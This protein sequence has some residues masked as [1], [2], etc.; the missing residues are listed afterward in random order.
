MGAANLDELLTHAPWLRRLA[1]QLVRDAAAADDLAQDVWLAA[2]RDAPPTLRN[3]KAWLA[4]VARSLAFTGARSTRRRAAREEA[5]GVGADALAAD[6]VVV[7]AEREREVARRVMALP[8]PYRTVV[9]MRFYRDQKPSEIARALGRPVATV[10][11]QLQRGLE[12]LRADLAREYGGS[13]NWCALLAPLLMRRSTASA[14]AGGVVAWTI[15]L[16]LGFVAWR[17]NAATPSAPVAA[18]AETSQE[19]PGAVRDAD[20]IALSSQRESAP[21]QLDGASEENSSPAPV[22]W[23]ERTLAP[24]RGRLISLDGAPLVGVVVEVQDRGRL[25]LADEQ[26]SALVANN[27]WLAVPA[28]LRDPAR[29]GANELNAFLD[30][31]FEDPRD[32]RELLLGRGLQPESSVTADDGSFEF[33]SSDASSDVAVRDSELT[34]VGWRRD[35]TSEA[36]FARAWIAAPARRLEVRCRTPLGA[37]I[38]GLKVELAARLSTPSNADATQ[39]G[40][41]GVSSKTQTLVS[42]ADGRLVFERA[43][44]CSV[45]L[46][47]DLGRAAPSLDDRPPPLPETW[48]VELVASLPS[49]DWELTG[50][51]LRPDD[52]PARFGTVFFGGA[53][54]G[55]G[56]DGRFELRTAF[57]APTDALVLLEPGFDPLLVENFGARF[58]SNE[59]RVDAGEL[60]LPD[61]RNSLA[62]VV[63]DGNGAPAANVAVHLDDPTWIAGLRSLETV[64][65]LAGGLLGGVRTDELGRFEVRGLFD[66]DYALS[67]RGDGPPA[68][69]GTFHV[70]D[71]N[72]LIRLPPR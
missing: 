15:V 8:E 3:P 40:S 17:W 63:L 33:L 54:V 7:E 12:R 50:V 55:I 59:R 38:V 48:S 35:T 34:I 2:M 28:S 45:H 43:P 27:F 69:A 61:T 64:E 14:L 23:K 62:G 32:A 9:L 5:R 39:T 1:T 16:G 4:T 42:D 71:S 68:P 52:T 53:S 30:A 66:R 11:V 51:A 6:D 44:E 24:V 25:R 18:I 57:V 58:G 21:A 36:R 13:A 72:V 29:I 26:R 20:K 70:G 47:A 31:H 46:S 10:K 56:S 67:V 49:T 65:S 19:G 22:R 37:P 60:R 41:L